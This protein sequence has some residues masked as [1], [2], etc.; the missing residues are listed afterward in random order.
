[1]T[2]SKRTSSVS[3]SQ[4]IDA[5]RRSGMIPTKSQSIPI[6]N[7]IL[8]TASE[9]QLCIDEYDAEQ[10]DYLFYARLV[11]GISQSQGSCQN[12]YIRMENQMCLTHIMQTRHDHPTQSDQEDWSLGLS[13]DTSV[14]LLHVIANDALELTTFDGD[15]ECVFELDL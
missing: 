6:S 7:S 1:M 10:R 15:E 13:M 4:P 11:N 5:S 2:E 12:K 8:R 9:I 14:D 3:I